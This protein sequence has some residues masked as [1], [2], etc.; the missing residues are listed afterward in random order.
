MARSAKCRKKKEVQRR[1]EIKET[2]GGSPPGEL[3]D[4]EKKVPYLKTNKTRRHTL[5]IK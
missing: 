1:R 5:W 4:V 3:T 2:G